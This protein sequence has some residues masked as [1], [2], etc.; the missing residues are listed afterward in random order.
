M[1]LCSFLSWAAWFCAASFAIQAI[2]SRG[3]VL[4][5]LL[6]AG[7]SVLVA[8]WGVRAL[9]AHLLLPMMQGR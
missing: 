4:R 5:S 6:F 1:F 7:V 3:N 8:A 9:C 2:M